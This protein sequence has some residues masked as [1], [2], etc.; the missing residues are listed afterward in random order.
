MRRNLVICLLLAGLTLALYWPVR[1]FDL[2]FF[3]DPL[4]LT[5]CPEIQAGLTWASV[6]WAF[7]SV[8]IANW[9]PVTNLSFLAVSQFFGTAPGAHHLANAIIHAASAA[10]LFLLLRRLTGATWRSAVAAAIFAWHPQRVESVAWIV[11]RKDVLCGFFFLLTLLC[12]TRAV[13]SGGGQV[14]SGG[15]APSRATRHASRSYWLA[16]ICFALALM[17][18][19]MAVTLPFVLLLLDVWPLRRVTGDPWHVTE[20]KKL[21]LEKWPFFGLMVLFCAVTYW[22]QHDYAAMTPW[23][24]LGPAPRAA[25]AIAS[26]LAYPAQF[27]WPMNLAATYPFPK[28]FDGTQTALK[29]ALLLAIS[30]GCLRQ[31]TR[32]PWLAV[33]W[34]WYLGT[35]LPIIGLVQVGEQAMADRYT[36]LPL[37]GPVVALVWTAAEMFARSRGGKI[38]L[39]ATAALILSA[40]AVLSA[41]QLQ[42]WRNTVALFDH[43]IAVTPENASAYYT[44]GLG[45][46]YTGD[47]RHAIVCY[48]VA[49]AINPMTFARQNLA[50]LLYQQGLLA[51]AESESKE[52]LAMQPDDVPAHISL[53]GI[54]AAQGRMDEALFQLN[55]A[56][57]LN[58]DSAEALNNLAW[59]LATSARPDLRDGP[60]AVTLAQ[61]AC[62]LTQFHKTI[63]IGTLAAA[64]AEAGKF[65]E[66]IATAQRACDLA[67]KNGETKLLQRNQE[68]LERY[69]RHHPAR[70]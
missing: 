26:Y 37:I 12:Y 5:T 28:S 29:A 40:L 6:K 16:L 14:T 4:L 67:A 2:I 56:V 61:H 9:Q 15:Q 24:K 62:E 43:N 45:L 65:G 47:T 52:V 1:S 69:R 66:A 11:E 60:R 35:A 13:T 33:G 38:V 20:W 48:R 54:F 19:P 39:T 17:S 51:A 27:L 10:L 21:A 50:N 25:N 36:Y 63:F 57:R 22:I 68:L 8:V 7:T 30:L 46:E 42:F 32:R 58:P 59:M 53:G 34:F 70:E 49:K 55:E 23:E 31:L 44:L 64:Q 18:K 3:D 41:R